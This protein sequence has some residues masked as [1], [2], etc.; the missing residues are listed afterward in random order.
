MY[1][2]IYTRPH[3]LLSFNSYRVKIK[4]TYLLTY[5]LTC[6]AGFFPFCH[7]FFFLPK[8]RGR[9]PGPPLVPPLTAASL[10]ASVK[11]TC[12]T[13]QW[14]DDDDDVNH[15]VDDDDDDDGGGSG[16]GSGSDDDDDLD[17]A[18]TTINQPCTDSTLIE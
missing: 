18:Q 16:A 4:V 17:R 1:I 5:L 3:K 2:Y 8:I 14:N 10:V 12:L 13:K 7:F 15:D 11:V 6:P 9:G